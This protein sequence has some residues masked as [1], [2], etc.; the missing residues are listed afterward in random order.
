MK[1]EIS[2]NDIHD[3]FK[4]VK[5]LEERRFEYSFAYK[6]RHYSLDREP[7]KLYKLRQ[8]TIAH[9]K[10]LNDII[11]T[12]KEPQLNLDFSEE[13]NTFVNQNNS[14]NIKNL[15]SNEQDSGN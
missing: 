15:F 3:L 5:F 1:I 9:I 13:R 8:E 11:K 12:T 6:N 10:C 4:I 2:Q 7:M 14:E